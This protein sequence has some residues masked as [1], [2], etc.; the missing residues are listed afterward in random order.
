MSQTTRI[1]IIGGGWPGVAH[2]KGY[3]TAG[4]FTVVAVADL[5]P[6]R[7]ARLAADWPNAKQYADAVELIAD[8]NV[9]AVSLCLPTHL[10]LPMALLAMKKGK[11]VILETPPGVSLRESRQLA[12]AANKRGKVLM[13]AFQRRFGGAELA[14]AQAIEKGYPRH[15]N[16][17]RVVHR[18]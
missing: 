3:L 14:A 18:S 7:R 2:A 5:I 16:R 17:H 4:G 13:Y 11:H 8:P 12:A 9:E 10:H 15:S 1:G 6:D